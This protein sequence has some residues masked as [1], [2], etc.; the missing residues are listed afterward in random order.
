MRIDTDVV[1]SR[2]VAI[3]YKERSRISEKKTYCVS[4]GWPL[5]DEDIIAGS[6]Y[7]F[8]VASLKG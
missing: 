8:R 6:R 7:F 5:V 3:G 1:T 2:S 4:V